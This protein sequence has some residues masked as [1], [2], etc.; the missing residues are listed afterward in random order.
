[1]IKVRLNLHGE[2]YLYTSDASLFPF[3]YFFNEFN[4]MSSRDC[5]HICHNDSH[6]C[7]ASS[8]IVSRM[9]LEHF[10]PQI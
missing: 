1:M 9:V 6:E 10:H 2:H 7:V 8:K 4:T 5:G 3:M